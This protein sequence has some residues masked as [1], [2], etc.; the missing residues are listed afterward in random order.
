MNLTETTDSPCQTCDATIE[1]LT[2]HE[3]PAVCLDC[4]DAETANEYLTTIRTGH[5]QRTAAAR[6]IE[7]AVYGAREHGAT[8]AQIGDALTITKQA[9]QQRYGTT[10]QV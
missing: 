3:A 2:N 6:T 5:A 1:Y 9:A 8:W 4:Q 7:N 10:R